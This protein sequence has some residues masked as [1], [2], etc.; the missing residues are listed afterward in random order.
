MTS[1]GGTKA[2]VV[3]ETVP[4]LIVPDPRLS[5]P[6]LKEIVPVTPLGTTAVTV[7]LPPYVLG[8]EVVTVT[9][10]VA[11]FTTCATMLEVSVP[12]CEVILC[13]PTVRLEVVRLAVAPEIVIVPIFVV[14]SKNDTVPDFPLGKLVVKVTDWR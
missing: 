5:D 10:G 4:E 3:T 9:V 2:V 13:V 11:L 12:N 8:P 14:P 1:L 6:L 7:T